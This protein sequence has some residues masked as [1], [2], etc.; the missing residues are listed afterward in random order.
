MKQRKFYNIENV[1]DYSGREIIIAINKRGE[2]I[3]FISTEKD[4]NIHKVICDECSIENTSISNEYKKNKKDC[5]FIKL[6]PNPKKYGNDIDIAF[7]YN[8]IS[9][10]E[11]LKCVS[12]EKNEN[13]SKKIISSTIIELVSKNIVDQLNDKKKSEVMTID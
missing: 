1:L 6:S 4:D 11:F 5:D 8:L 9:R 3:S 12:K 7:K 13:K 2:R 10:E